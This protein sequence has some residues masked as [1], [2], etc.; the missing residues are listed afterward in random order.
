MR[1]IPRRV[2]GIVV[3]HRHDFIWRGRPGSGFTFPCDAQG[4]PLSLCP[5]GEANYR[6]CISGEYD[7]ID[8]GIRTRRYEQVEPRHGICQCGER[9]ALDSFTCTCPGCG[10]DYNSSGQLL[11]PRSQWGDDTGESVADILAIDGMT[12]EEVWDE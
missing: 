2:I 4:Q 6:R 12:D 1:V 11:A 3:E 5:E 10:R 7:V 8:E 9:V